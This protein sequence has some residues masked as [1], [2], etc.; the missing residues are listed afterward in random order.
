MR[1]SKEFKFRER[2]NLTF[3]CQLFDVTNRAN[4]GTQYTT[5][6]KSKTFGQPANF[7]STSGT[8]VPHAFQAEMGFV[9]RF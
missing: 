9:Y 6:I 4:F 2:Q 7:L 3:I 8:N 5:S 1:V